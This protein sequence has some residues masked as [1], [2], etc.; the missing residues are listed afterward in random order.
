MVLR[1][2]VMGGATG[3]KKIIVEKNVEKKSVGRATGNPTRFTGGELFEKRPVFLTKRCSLGGELFEKRP[4][5]IA[6]P[7]L[8]L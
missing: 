1:S 6:G 5:F 4:M 3:E 2:P 7:T 8:K